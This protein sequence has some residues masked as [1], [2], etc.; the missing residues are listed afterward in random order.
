[1]L[2]LE[3]ALGRVMSAFEPLEPEQVRIIEALGQVLAG[4]VVAKMDIPPLANTAMDGYAVRCDDTGGALPDRPRRLRVVADLAA[5]Y[6]LE[7]PIHPGTAVRI[8]TGAPVPPGAEAVVPFEEVERDG[9]EILVFKRYPHNKNIR[10]AGEDVHEG[11]RVLR[12]GATLRPQEIGMLAA[13][14]HSTVTVH[15]RPR[16]AILSTGDEV[17]GVDAPWQPGKIRDANSYSNAA[18]VVRYGGVPIRLG[19]ARDD[20]NE[21]TSKIEAGLEQGADLFLTS[22][23]VSV[24]DFDVVKEVL[25]AEG[26]MNF[27]RVRMKPG[28]PLA[29]GHIGPSAGSGR[30]VPML[31]LPGNPV[32]AMISFE[33]FARRAILKMLGKTKWEKPTVEATLLDEIKRKDDRRHFLRVMLEKR[34]GEYVARLTGDQGSGILLSMV[35]AQG[36]AVIPEDVNRLP[37]GAEVQ[38]VMLIWPER[39]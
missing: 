13:L 14:G 37:A 2:D 34:N 24:G 31:G 5:G 22:G 35:K 16:V 17:I 20:V 18:Q 38:V 7:E 29:F 25:S 21:L 27:W 12:S 9:D 33:I 6:V 30:S 1:M 28:K 39:E 19:I 32:S 26:E 4:D 8:M 36:L 10:A 11:Q 3:E 23:G 15:R